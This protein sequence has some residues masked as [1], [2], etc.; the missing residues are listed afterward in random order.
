MTAQ[1]GA[2]WIEGLTQECAQFQ[3][4][5]SSLIDG[6]IEERAAGRAIAHL[7]TCAECRTF[8]DD[9]RQQVRAHRDAAGQGAAALQAQSEGLLARYKDLLGG[10]VASE[11][12]SIELVCR[13]TN[14]FYQLGKA[15]TLAAIDPGYR[16]RVFEAAVALEP[17]RTE[18][19][20]FVDG[21]VA[22]G[23][24]RL[25]GVDWTGARHLFNGTLTRIEGALEKGKRLLDEALKTDPGHEEARLYVALIA[26]HEGHTLK[27]FRAF[28]DLFETA[29]HDVNRGHAA[30]QL[31]LLHSDEEDFEKAIAYTRWLTMSGL[32]DREP[33]FFFARFNLGTYYARLRQ[34]ERALAT[35]RELLDR[36]PERC[37]EVA[38]FFGRAVKLHACIE[39]QAGFAEKLLAQCP[40]LF[41]PPGEAAGQNRLP[42]PENPR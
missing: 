31:A 30:V 5:L 2:W 10:R 1:S 33:R 24:G 34:P 17:T 3:L 11:V 6:E 37:A 22:S 27:A 25:V 26:K 23:R 35:F 36:Y 28:S 42:S 14:I 38:Q 39:S 15:Y 21:V 16:T 32:A 7:E 8:F 4:D 19:R 13:L 40:E 41:Q 9:A 12:E 29:V 20:G 18:G